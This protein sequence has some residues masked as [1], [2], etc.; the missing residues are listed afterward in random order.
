MRLAEESGGRGR[1][2]VWR[3]GGG[4]SRG[5]GSGASGTHPGEEA[6]AELGP[7]QALHVEH[8]GALPGGLLPALSPRRPSSPAVPSRAGRG[9]D[10]SERP[11]GTARPRLRP[12]P[13]SPLLAAPRRCCRGAGRRP[14]GSATVPELRYRCRDSAAGRV[15]ALGSG[16]ARAAGRDAARAARGLATSARGPAA[17]L[18][19]TAERCRRRRAAAC[20]LRGAAAGGARRSQFASPRCVGDK[21]KCRASLVKGH[22]AGLLFLLPL[23]V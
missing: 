8:V 5:P 4:Q 14:A 21:E 9:A 1:G 6:L 17:A 20:V 12:A 18:S 13:A 19:P 23:Q 2:Q 7:L 3:W 15:P 10:T 16:R 11:G 22:V